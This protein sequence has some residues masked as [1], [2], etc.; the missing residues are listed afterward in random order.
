MSQQGPKAAKRDM[1]RK[2]SRQRTL[3][4][5]PSP[6]V[7][8]CGRRPSIVII[9]TADMGLGDPGCYSGTVAKTPPQF[10]LVEI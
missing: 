4:S 9:L 8:Y 7:I 3:A 6:T 5:E 2:G 1:P 10:R